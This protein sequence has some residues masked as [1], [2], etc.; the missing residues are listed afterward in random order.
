MF[1]ENELHSVFNLENGRFL[2]LSKP[3]KAFLYYQSHRLNLL[4]GER[5]NVGVDRF[6]DELKLFNIKNSLEKEAKRV[7]HLFFELGYLFHNIVSEEIALAID[8]EY[9]QEEVVKNKAKFTEMGFSISHMSFEDYHHSFKEVMTNLKKGNCYQV[10]LT[11]PV[12]VDFENIDLKTLVNSFYSD[13]KKLGRFAHHTY[14]PI[15]DKLILSNSPE[16]LFEIKDEKIFSYPIKGTAKNHSDLE[17]QKNLAELNMIIDL[18]RNDLSRIDFEISTVEKDLELMAVPGLKHQY[19]TISVPL[20]QNTSLYRLLFCLFPGGSITGAPKLRVLNLIKKIECSQR[21]VYC[22]STILALKGTLKSSIN[23][24][25][26]ESQS[27][28]GSFTYGAGGGVTIKSE[29]KD[30]YKEAQLKLDSFLSLLSSS[31]V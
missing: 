6:L 24:R 9:E 2:K 7:F 19:A 10:N 22:G 25:T 15:L 11:F 16:C 8:L 5:E 3:R 18:V 20:T 26:L 12:K 17:T 23:I 29:A 27:D 28:K 1:S 4:S 31:K 13:L 30:E 21:Q 14:I